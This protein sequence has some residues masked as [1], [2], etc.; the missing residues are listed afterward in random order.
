MYLVGNKSDMKCVV[1]EAEGERKAI[2]NRMEYIETSAKDPYQ[3]DILF[4]RMAKMLIK[5]RSISLIE[6]NG[7]SEGPKLKLHGIRVLEDK[8]CCQ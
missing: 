1:E 2:I 6:E 5:Q 3:V 7:K 8:H 4:E